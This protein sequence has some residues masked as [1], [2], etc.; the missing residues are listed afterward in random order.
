MA[1]M[2]P[3]MPNIEEQI[4]WLRDRAADADDLGRL[5]V[6]CGHVDAARAKRDAEMWRACLS[7]LEAIATESPA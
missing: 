7:T 5:L 6:T 4:A 2:I 3:E 1:R